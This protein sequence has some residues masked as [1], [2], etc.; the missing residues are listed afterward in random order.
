MKE[1]GGKR[2]KRKAPTSH[3]R[4][5]GGSQ[6][7]PHGSGK[8]NLEAQ[9]TWIVM[10][11]RASTSSPLLGPLR[12]PGLDQ[13]LQVRLCRNPDRGSRGATSS[14]MA[15]GSRCQNRDRQSVIPSLWVGHSKLTCVEGATLTGW[16]LGGKREDDRLDA[17][18]AFELG[19]NSIQQRDG[20]SWP[21]RAL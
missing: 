8:P 12:A 14:R 10:F 3:C 6:G 11:T 2:H 18:V 15:N 9:I 19:T 13:K 4:A 7:H 20:S 5:G 21:P 17:G 16:G 1:Q